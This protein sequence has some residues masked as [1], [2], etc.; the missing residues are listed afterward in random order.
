LRTVLRSIEPHFS[1]LSDLELSKR[2]NLGSFSSFYLPKLS[3]DEANRNKRGAEEKE[4]EAAETEAESGLDKKNG[5]DSFTSFYL[6]KVS[7]GKRQDGLNSFSSF[8]VPKTVTGET[9]SPF[10]V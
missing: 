10:C 1:I 5:L 4:A 9:A 6:P 2:N 3:L 7:S 8:Y